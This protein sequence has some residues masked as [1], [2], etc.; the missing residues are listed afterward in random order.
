M[1][2]AGGVG[3]FAHRR[4]G[5]VAA[6][7]LPGLI[8]G[9]LLGTYLGGSFAHILAEGILRIVFAAVLVWTGVR[10]LQTSSAG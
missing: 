1:V 7:L 10:Y 4:L 3:A 2:P 5:N 6:G 8:P 9:I